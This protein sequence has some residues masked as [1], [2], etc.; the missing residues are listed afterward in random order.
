MKFTRDN[1]TLYYDDQG[2]SEPADARSTILCIHG[3]PLGRKMWRPQLTGLCA[4]YRILAPDLRGFG[5]SDPAP[6]PYPM[7]LLAD[8][9]AALLD[10][11]Q[12]GDPVTV[13]GLSMGGYIA[14][15]FS[16]RYPQRLRGL[17]L[18]AT[19]AQPDSADA[20]ANRLK[21]AALAEKEGPEAIARAMLPKMLSAA[22]QASN[23]ETVSKVKAIMQEASVP[24][25]VGALMGMRERPD[26]TPTLPTIQVP[27]LI[28]RGDDDPFASREEAEAM[29]EAIPHAQLIC[30]PNA[31]H[32]PN[33]E[34]PERFNQAVLAWMQQN[35]H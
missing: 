18:A 31:A 6:G 20:A 27:T 15:A 17:I 11:L 28:L 26:S 1:I 14:F 8:D 33:L 13:C 16:R 30:I 5:D 21:A 29:C 4:Q 10:H 19:R 3:Y 12:I 7:D 9:C 34:Q 23:P 2:P 24:G 22:T 25:I 35:I 32:L